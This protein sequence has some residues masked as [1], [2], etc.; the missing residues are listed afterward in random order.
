M[1]K[2]L[3][4]VAFLLT[5]FLPNSAIDGFASQSQVPNAIDTLAEG[6]QKTGHGWT[7]EMPDKESLRR[8]TSLYRDYLF[9]A[10]GNSANENLDS[11]NWV[12]TLWQR[13]EGG[14]LSQSSRVCMEQAKIQRHYLVEFAGNDAV[15]SFEKTIP[16]PENF[17]KQVA[18]SKLIVKN[19]MSHVEDMI[20]SAKGLRPSIWNKTVTCQS[21][22]I[23][24]CIMYESAIYSL[25]Q[26]KE[27]S[28]N[29]KT[30]EWVSELW[31]HD[32]SQ[33]SNTPASD[34]AL[35][36]YAQYLRQRLVDFSGSTAVD[37]YD[38]D[39]PSSS[40]IR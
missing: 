7:S 12:Q 1:K 28:K 2:G 32:G 22:L 13:C 19:R 4:G 35:R 26:R 9:E 24:T 15:M 31:K 39:M 29:L 37:S 3:L 21:D 11:K 27:N 16:F 36:E 40:T 8:I 25:D 33:G 6:A 10:V 20:N 23:G 34:G 17:S 14:S 18:D 38:R 30:K 5:V